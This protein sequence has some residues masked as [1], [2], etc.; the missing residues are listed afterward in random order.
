MMNPPLREGRYAAIVN[1]AINNVPS[2]VEVRDGA[3]Y[4]E[5]RAEKNRQIAQIAFRPTSAFI[6]MAAAKSARNLAAA[7]PCDLAC[8]AR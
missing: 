8:C 4:R 6:L 1:S 7:H 5:S 2:N 3:G